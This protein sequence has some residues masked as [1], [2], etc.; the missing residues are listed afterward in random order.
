MKNLIGRLGAI[1]CTPSHNHTYEKRVII[2]QRGITF[3]NSWWKLLPNN[4]RIRLYRIWTK[5]IYFFWI[6]P[7][8]KMLRKCLPSYAKTAQLFTS[9][10]KNL[11]MLVN[12]INYISWTPLHI[13]FL[14]KNSKL[15]RK[16]LNFWYFM[17]K[18]GPWKQIT[19]EN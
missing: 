17:R 8:L 9:Y 6:S 16:R 3:N 18:T 19:Q 15:L 12:K 7:Q 11:F 5:Q 4:H 14:A 10:D 1:F 2:W 13:R